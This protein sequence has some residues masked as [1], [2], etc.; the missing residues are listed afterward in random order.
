MN[1]A[2]LGTFVATL[3]M[4][5]V[6]ML[7]LGFGLLARVVVAFAIH[8]TAPVMLRRSEYEPT[9]DAHRQGYHDPQ[10]SGTAARSVD[11]GCHPGSPA[12]GH[13]GCP[14]RG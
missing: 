1:G 10:A 7:A 14:G 6:A 8:E 12:T 13:F 2:W 3:F 11:H 5:A 4:F 9:R